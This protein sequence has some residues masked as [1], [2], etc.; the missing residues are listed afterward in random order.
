MASVQTTTRL[1]RARQTDHRSL[2]TEASRCYNEASRANNR[3]M[4][5]QAAE[6]AYQAWQ[7]DSDYIPGINL[8]ARI[9]MRRG[10]FK[11]AHHW[12][13]TGLSIKPE[14]TGLLYSAGHL[15]L[16]EGQLEVAADY[17]AHATRISRTSTKAPLYLAH[18]RLLQ[19][20][21]LEAFQLYRELIK[22]RSDDTQV[23]NKLFEAASYIVA[24]FYSQELEAELLRWFEFDDVDH[25]QLRSLTT[26][27]LTHK[28]HLTEAGCPVE[29]ENIAADP[30]LLKAMRRFHFCDPLIERL[31]LTLRQSLLLTSSRDLAIKSEYMPL[32]IALAAQCELNESVWFITQQEQQLVSQLNQLADRIL[33][34]PTLKAR[35]LSAILL[36]TMMYQPLR[37]AP[38]Y[39][40]LTERQLEWPEDLRELMQACLIQPEYISRLRSAIPSL[41]ASTDL[42]SDK[43]QQ[44]Y[45]EHPY[46][47]WTSL[48]YNQKNDYYG[49]LQ[50]LFPGKLNNL[51][52][53]SGPIKVLIAGC[54][55]G[56]HALRLKRYFHRMDVTAL[57]LSLSS[58][59]Y[60][61]YQSERYGLPV[62]FIQ[63]DLLL[64]NRLGEEFDVIESSGVLHHMEHPE[65]GLHALT[66]SLR[67][68]GVMKI[69]LY[70]RRART[71]INELREEL[72]DA[73][74]ENEQDIRTVRE[75][76]L[77]QGNGRWDAI[78]Q[79]PDF[80]SMSS[81]RDLLFHTQEHTFDLQEVRRLVD[82]ANLEWIG[83]VPPAGAQKLAEKVLRLPPK[84]LTLND[85]HTLEQIE[86]AL[87][88]GMY[89]FYVRKP[90]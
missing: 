39:A 11:E 46:P 36:L 29:P 7:A 68:G 56:R 14:S 85:W 80:Y 9:A 54:G 69:A 60:A 89:Q 77:Q 57:D 32:V 73:I 58:L 28:L 84:N 79:S 3:A 47:R 55:T 16:N 25:S 71:L 40:Q 76:L 64:I 62:D 52:P 41:G 38:C 37:K 48:G 61:Q 59:G 75:A 27:L 70:S 8:L 12:L 63:G 44:Q 87:F 30:L 74:P 5:V 15:A 81:V 50:A 51:Q 18:I 42:V 90:L 82:S 4:L 43:V 49:S 19:G 33:Q 65:A 1:D 66:N 45:E 72:K 88:A 86:P 13:D 2:L 53:A 34:I 35:D 17:F 22:T 23:R 83:I 21:Y 10:E 6:L 67:P 20:E 24:D 26:S 31:L 78:L